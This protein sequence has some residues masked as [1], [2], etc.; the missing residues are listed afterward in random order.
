MK[1]LK[2]QFLWNILLFSALGCFSLFSL[3]E[4]SEIPSSKGNLLNFRN[5]LAVALIYNGLGLSILYINRKIRSIDRIYP[6]QKRTLTLFVITAALSIL[7]INYLLLAGAKW[8]LEIGSPF[9]LGWNGAKSLMIVWLVELIIISQLLA[10]NFYISLLKLYKKNEELQESEAQSRYMALQNQLNPHFLFNS[11]N[12]LVSEIEYDPANAV[13][14][15]RTLSD[16][17]RYI[18]QSQDKQTVSLEDELEFLDSFLFLHKVR[19]GECI[20]TITDIPEDL[21]DCQLPPLSLQLLAENM[22]KHNIINSSRPMVLKIYVEN[23]NWLCVENTYRPKYHN[24]KSGKG[25]QNLSQRYELV[26]GEKIKIY[27]D[28]KIFKVSIPLLYE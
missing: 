19:I 12:T 23:G 9:R 2:I 27:Q 1:H 5:F 22:I 6:R 20:Q 17:Y 3:S 15:T 14:F 11:L 16:V 8:I 21:Y 26:S 4:F 28:E 18:L 7:I 25:L 24:E 13:K 10:N